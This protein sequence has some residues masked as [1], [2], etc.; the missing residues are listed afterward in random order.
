MDVGEL[1][2]FKVFFW[3][4]RENQIDD[5]FFWPSTLLSDAERF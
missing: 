5:D 1:L 3:L 2:S 4:F